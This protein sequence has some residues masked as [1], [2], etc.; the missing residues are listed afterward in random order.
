MMDQQK[1]QEIKKKYEQQWLS[2]QGVVGVGIGIL[3]DK[4]MGI[5]VS[6]VKLES[7]VT[8]NIPDEIEGVKIEIRETGEFKAL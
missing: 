2:I 6:V 1:I 5:I 7:H 8:S 4:N 3:D